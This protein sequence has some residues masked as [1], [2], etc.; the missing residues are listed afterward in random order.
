MT[1]LK[2]IFFSKKKKNKRICFRDFFHI[3]LLY[4]LL[5]STHIKR[6]KKNDSYGL[7]SK[8]TCDISCHVVLLYIF[9]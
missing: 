3:I 8:L 5:F 6:E 7:L 4:P 2:L 9:F 1:K